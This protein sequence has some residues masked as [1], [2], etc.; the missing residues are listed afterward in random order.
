MEKKNDENIIKEIFEIVLLFGMIVIRLFPVGEDNILIKS[1]G[2]IGVV[3]SV[4]DLYVDA[5]REYSMYDKFHVIKGWAYVIFFVLA[6]ILLLVLSGLVPISA[7]WSDIFTLMALLITLPERL[8]IQLIGKYING[9]KE[10]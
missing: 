7:M 9:G 4:I 3:V 5:V 8:Y 6:I 2:Y 1:V 10:R